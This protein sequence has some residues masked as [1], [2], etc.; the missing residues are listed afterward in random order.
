MIMILTFM[1]G[2]HFKMTNNDII[3][4]WRDS[5]YVISREE[6]FNNSRE[7]S[8][9]KARFDNIKIGNLYD[10]SCSLTA[11]GGII[12]RHEF[13][14]ENID[15]NYKKLKKLS[16]IIGRPN[17]YEISV[18]FG[19]HFPSRY[20]FADYI[21]INDREDVLFEEIFSKYR[22]DKLRQ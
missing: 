1:V 14:V 13:F 2:I 12:G 5:D 19:K 18:G 7:D 8:Q 6:Y 3:N 16:K 10:H 9:H 17:D 11:F 21:K 22:Y 15:G 4:F 20:I